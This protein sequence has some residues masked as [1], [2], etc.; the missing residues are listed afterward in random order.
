[1]SLVSPACAV[2]VCGKWREIDQTHGDTST[3]EAKKL[4]SDWGEESQ[5]ANNV[6]FAADGNHVTYKLPEGK[7]RGQTGREIWNRFREGGGTPRV[8]IVPIP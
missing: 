7:A 5:K 2:T 8:V 1:M 4:K 3:V 6:K